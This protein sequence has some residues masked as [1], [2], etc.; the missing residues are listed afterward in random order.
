[1]P[2]FP[3][4]LYQPREPIDTSIELILSLMQNLNLGQWPMARSELH[5]GHQWPVPML[6]PLKKLLVEKVPEYF[7][8]ECPRFKFK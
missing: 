2:Y 3:D 5:D 8:A 1:M 6:E 7:P 4:C